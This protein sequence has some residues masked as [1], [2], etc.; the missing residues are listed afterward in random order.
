MIKSKLVAKYKKKNM[1]MM[2]EHI[3]SSVNSS[4]IPLGDL[5]GLEEVIDE[6]RENMVT[7]T[8]LC[9]TSATNIKIVLSD[10]LNYIL[11]HFA[12]KKYV[13]GVVIDSSSNASALFSV[14]NLNT[15]ANLDVM[16]SAEYTV[17]GEFSEKSKT[18]HECKWIKNDF[19]DI[20][21]AV[22]HNTKKFE[23]VENINK[24]S[25]IGGS[26]DFSIF[27]FEGEYQNQNSLKIYIYFEQ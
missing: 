15:K 25:M 7:G 20:V 10:I 19:P 1:L 26:I 4:V 27:S 13:I 22:E 3:V 17:T 16:L 6:S 21:T 23:R 9:P 12:L 8:E 14:K 18:E 24:N 11:D 2:K 5:V